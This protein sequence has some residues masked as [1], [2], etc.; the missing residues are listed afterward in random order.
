MRGHRLRQLS[1][2]IPRILFVFAALA[3]A[4]FL[5]ARDGGKPVSAASTFAPTFAVTLADKTAGAASD[6]NVTLSIPGGDLNFASVNNA[7]PA[8]SF[9]A[10]GPGNPAFV[11]GTNPANGDVIGTLTSNTFLG[12]TNNPC[13]SNLTVNFTFMNAT[14]N[15]AVANQINPVTPQSGHSPSPAG[16]QEDQWTDDGSAPSTPATPATAPVNGLPADVDLYPGFLNAVFDPHWLGYGPDGVYGG[17]DDVTDGNPEAPVQPLARYVGNTNVAGTIV[18]LNLVYFGDTNGNGINDLAEAFPAPHPY[19]DLRDVGYV[20]VAVLQDTTQPPSPSAITDFCSPLNV[21]TVVFGQTKS[22]PCNGSVLPPCNTAPGINTP[23]PGASTGKDRYRNPTTPNTYLWVNFAQSLRDSDQDGI[24]NAFDTCPNNVNTD[25]DPRVTSGPDADMIDSACDLTPLANTGAGNADGD[26]QNP[27]NNQAWQNAQDNCPQVANNDQVESEVTTAYNLAAKRGGPK[28]DSIGDACDSQPTVANGIFLTVLVASPNCIGSNTGGPKLDGDNDGWC[29]TL[30]GGLP[31]DPND[32]NASLTP[33][34][35]NIFYP[36]PVA[37][38]GS[39]P[40]PPMRQPVQVCND[41][42]DNDGDGLIDN[43]DSGCKPVGVQPAVTFPTC[44]INGCTNDLDGDGYSN[45]AE[46]LIG[47]DALGRCEVGAVP[48]QSTDWPSDF[49]SGG[50]PNSTDRITITDLTSFIAPSA[51]RHLDTS[52]GDANYNARWDLV[53]GPG[54]FAK[55]ININ[56]LT[57]LIAGP[58]GFPPMFS[59]AKAFGSGLACSPHP[60]YG[61]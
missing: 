40:T 48:A 33:E 31:A 5:S 38:S 27:G 11:G 18:T 55:W 3:V 6:G 8:A 4:V 35:Y 16:A 34:D 21:T 9:V 50:I 36:F 41:G 12:L 53:P 54:L 32:G 7:S 52:P 15:N 24:E 51:S 45:E 30:G 23:I 44:P 56:D 20:S 47:T 1:S 49:S 17:G 57:S 46:I 29:S 42:I 25:G 26:V 58:S 43:R 59:G 61:D 22:N 2:W 37:H 39:G 14:V 10:P 60:V 13:N 28:T 19:S